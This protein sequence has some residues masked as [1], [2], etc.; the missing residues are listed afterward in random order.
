MLIKKIHDKQLFSGLQSSRRKG[1][2]RSEGSEDFLLQGEHGQG[3]QRAGLVEAEAVRQS[4]E[5]DLG[6]RGRIGLGN[7]ERFSATENEVCFVG[8]KHQY[9]FGNHDKQE[10]TCWE[11]LSFVSFA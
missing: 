9:H 6:E 2:L 11:I 8:R 4:G 1:E 3:G 10:S 7:K 5:D